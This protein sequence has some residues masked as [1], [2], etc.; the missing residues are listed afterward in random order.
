M[1]VKKAQMMPVFSYEGVDRKGEKL[2]GELPA[3][4]MALAKVT[5][6]KQGI[7]IKH[8]R[9]NEVSAML[10]A[11]NSSETIKVVF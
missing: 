11:K 5:L 7:T 3:R 6:R 10:K 4:N 9:E 2:K 1:V 8:I